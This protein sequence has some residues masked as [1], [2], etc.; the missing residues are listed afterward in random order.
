[1]GIFTNEFLDD[2]LNADHANY[3]L[4]L[5]CICLVFV[6]RH[7]SISHGCTHFFS[8]YFSTESSL[9]QLCSPLSLLQGWPV[10]C[11]LFSQSSQ[12]TVFRCSFQ[13]TCV[14]EPVC[15]LNDCLRCA[16]RI[17]LCCFNKNLIELNID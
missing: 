1:M 7:G 16:A 3:I 15:L 13:L 11:F 17:A 9:P 12:H 6:Y 8:L 5:H 4:L 2:V 10:P 14:C